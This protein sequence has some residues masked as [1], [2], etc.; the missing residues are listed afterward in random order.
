[1]KFRDLLA[2]LFLSSLFASQIQSNFG[3][4]NISLERLDTGDGQYIYYG[5][6]KPETATE[7]TKAPFIAII[8][9][10]PKN[11]KKPYLT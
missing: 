8:P 1:M 7:L 2:I 3:K 10:F 4:T 11:Q 6:Y 5:L 9:G